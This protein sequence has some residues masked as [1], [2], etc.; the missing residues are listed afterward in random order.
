MKVLPLFSLILLS[1]F[2][3]TSALS[4]LTKEQAADMVNQYL[5]NMPANSEIAKNFEKTFY[6]ANKKRLCE[7]QPVLIKTPPPKA[8]T[9]VINIGK[10]ESTFHGIDTHTGQYRIRNEHGTNSRLYCG[11]SYI[12]LNPKEGTN[13]PTRIINDDG[14]R[15]SP[16]VRLNNVTKKGQQC[17]FESITLL[18][19]KIDRR[20]TLENVKI[21]SNYS[22]PGTRISIERNNPILVK[23]M[24]RCQHGAFNRR[25]KGNQ[26]YPLIPKIPKGSI[27]T[28]VVSLQGS[29]CVYEQV[30]LIKK[31]N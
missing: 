6:Q 13:I 29:Q 31:Y 15:M 12:N 26:Q 2:F 24:P 22:G 11:T 16:Q 5:K 14:V 18:K 30:S 10:I 28:I 25:L 20:I 4:C 8:S 17:Y 21:T 19:P 3:S 1:S 27:I 7:N 23:E 9:E